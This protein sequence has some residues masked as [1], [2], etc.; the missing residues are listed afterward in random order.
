MTPFPAMLDTERLQNWFVLFGDAGRV[1]SVSQRVDDQEWRDRQNVSESAPLCIG[2]R[3]VNK[4]LGWT[5]S[6][7]R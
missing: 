1:N 5:S 7:F 2:R 6:M 4:R 3:R